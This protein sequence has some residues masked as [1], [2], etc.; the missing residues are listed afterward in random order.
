M[1]ELIE[2]HL[3]PFFL[4]SLFNQILCSLWP[5]LISCFSLLATAYQELA[6]GTVVTFFPLILYFQCLLFFLSYPILDHNTFPSHPIFHAASFLPYLSSQYPSQP[7]FYAAS[8]FPCFSPQYLFFPSHYLSHSHA[9]FC[10]LSCPTPVSF[11]LCFFV[12]WLFCVIIKYPQ[13]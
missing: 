12:F 1:D 6:S 2:V 9:F 7:I 11:D 13:L 10:P 5:E 3:V 8:F 4:C